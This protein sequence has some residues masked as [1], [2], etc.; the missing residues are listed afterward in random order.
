VT[1]PRRQ[2]R[3]AALQILYCWEIGRT[4]LDE[5]VAAYFEE[6]QPDAPEAVRRFARELAEGTAGEIEQLDR[7][8]G[9][10]ARHWRVERLAVLD[11]LILRLAVWE[12]RHADDTP[13]VVAVNE[14]IELAR[15]FS[16]EDAVR[17][18]NGV[19]DGVMK[20]EVN[21]PTSA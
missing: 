15:R 18:V 6:H 2:A 10:H 7:V 3:E 9:L 11:R 13:P 5:A 17:F 8:I 14:A 12:L 20:T 4:S 21:P 16:G 1:G 19:L